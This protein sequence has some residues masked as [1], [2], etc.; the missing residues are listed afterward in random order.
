M[1]TWILLSCQY[2]DGKGW[3]KKGKGRVKVV[4]QEVDVSRWQAVSRRR[5]MTAPSFS[6]KQLT[7]E[8]IWD[9]KNSSV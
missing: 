4:G 1:E 3:K 8:K 2:S 7:Q 6:S 9:F 5:E